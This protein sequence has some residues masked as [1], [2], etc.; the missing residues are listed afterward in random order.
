[1]TIFTVGHGTRTI[2]ELVAVVRPHVH[3][4]VDVRRYPG[5][6][7]NPQFNQEALEATLAEREVG[8]EWRGD[9]LGGRRAVS[10]SSRHVAWRVPAFQGYADYL[11]TA[12]ARAAITALAHRAGAAVMCAET[13]WWRCHRRLIADALVVR[14]VDVVHLLDIDKRQPHLLHPQLR[15]GDDGWPVYDVGVD[16]PLS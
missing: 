12:P 13:V 2:D 6:R 9:E 8:Y 7:R 11:D 14:G 5:S 1:M 16:R 15:V 3:T 10:A 4:I